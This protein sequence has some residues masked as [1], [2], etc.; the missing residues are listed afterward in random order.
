[1][2]TGR[3]WKTSVQ[4]A[5]HKPLKFQKSDHRPVPLFSK[6]LAQR[7]AVFH[8]AFLKTIFRDLQEL[9]LRENVPGLTRR[10]A[11]ARASFQSPASQYL[12][13]TR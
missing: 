6:S 4:A 8:F 1:M 13:V 9:S 11:C 3:T 2:A 12:T 10:A 7:S 5:T